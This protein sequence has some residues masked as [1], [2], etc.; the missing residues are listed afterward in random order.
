MGLGPGDP[1]YL[2]P[3]GL[4][5]LKEADVIVGYTTYIKLIDTHIIK[6]K[7]VITTGMRSEIERCKKA[8]EH[9]KQGKRVVLVSSGDP[10]IYGMAGPLLEL[11]E[12]EN[13]LINLEVVPGVPAFCAA[14]ALVGAAVMH[15][16]AVISL[17]DILTPWEVIK[18]RIILALEGDFVIVIYNPRSKKRT[19]QLEEIKN[20]IIQHKKGKLPV[21][22]I[23]NATRKNQRVFLTTV[24]NLNTDEI[25]MV[26]I[27]IVGNSSSKISNNWLI[28]PRGYNM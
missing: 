4:K 24:D 11:L 23:K 10:G 2:T 19:W 20:I 6:D 3:R 21:A 12:K 17:S 16:F 27:L 28:T 25:D 7:E 5:K 14:S 15:D 13:T 26:T 22:I 1:S 9:A 18:K 8:I